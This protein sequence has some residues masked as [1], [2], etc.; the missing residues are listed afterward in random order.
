[1]S[2]RVGSGR[3]PF[4]LPVVQGQP[5]PP[6]SMP[7]ASPVP[8][9][10]PA[11]ASSGLRPDALSTVPGDEA[12]ASC[13]QGPEPLLRA[14][15]WGLAPAEGEGS[16]QIFSLAH[17]PW[18]RACVLGP[19]DSPGRGRGGP[20]Q[21]L[22]WKTSATE[23]RAPRHAEPP[24]QPLPRHPGGQ[25]WARKLPR[26][27]SHF[28]VRAGRPP[29]AGRLGESAVACPHPQTASYPRMLPASTRLWS[30]RAPVTE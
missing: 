19:L 8:G 15:R 28:G 1:M 16:S 3:T 25:L 7:G 24:R 18:H 21:H 26:G 23:T 27:S 20:Q 29:A 14:P 12:G 2:P 22:P 11:S 30:A 17:S 6:A 13:P 10:L 4:H 5:P 9:P